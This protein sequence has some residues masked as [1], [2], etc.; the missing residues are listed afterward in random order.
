MEREREVDREWEV[1]DERWTTREVDEEGEGHRGRCTKREVDNS[2][3]IE[4]E[5]DKEEVNIENE[6]NSDR[7]TY[8]DIYL[9]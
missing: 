1:D 2:R 9:L 4:R 6:V 5:K 8:G 3:W 7:W